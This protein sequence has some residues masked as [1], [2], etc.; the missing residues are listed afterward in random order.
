LIN[1]PDLLF[2]LY[3]N[4]VD[5]NYCNHRWFWH[6]VVDIGMNHSRVQNHSLV[7]VLPYWNRY[8]R[9]KKNNNHICIYLFIHWAYSFPFNLPINCLLYHTHI[10]LLVVFSSSSFCAS[11][12]GICSPVV[13]FHSVIE[14]DKIISIDNDDAS[15]SITT[16]TVQLTQTYI[17]TGAFCAHSWR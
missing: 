1:L 5:Y 8:T 3:K 14:N 13:L 2:V 4:M 9:R 17:Y 7:V 16:I 10:C 12:C 11:C 6:F 15:H